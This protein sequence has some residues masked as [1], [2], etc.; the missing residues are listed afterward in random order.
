MKDPII[1]PDEVRALD[2]AR[3]AIVADCAEGWTAL[4][5]LWQLRL[6]PEDRR[7]IALAAAL[8]CEAED[9][10]EVHDFIVDFI[11]ADHEAAAA[12]ATDRAWRTA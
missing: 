10:E 1:T 7:N 12:E 3:I 5:R 4:S 11:R 9:L 2:V 8:S 6:R